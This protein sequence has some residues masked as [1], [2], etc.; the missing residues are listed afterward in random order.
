M[1]GHIPKDNKEAHPTPIIQEGQKD[2]AS[3]YSLTPVVGKMLGSI[4]GYLGSEQLEKCNLIRDGQWGGWRWVLTEDSSQVLLPGEGWMGMGWWELAFLKC[5]PG[6]Q[7]QS[8]TGLGCR[9][10]WKVFKGGGWWMLFVSR[11]RFGL[12][13]WNEGFGFCVCLPDSHRRPSHREKRE[14][15]SHPSSGTWGRS[16]NEFFWVSQCTPGAHAQRSL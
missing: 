12:K 13:K 11:A 6:M 16:L 14:L 8:F 10:H 7:Q 1:T 4:W 5:Q 15:G 3:N 9:A 2:A